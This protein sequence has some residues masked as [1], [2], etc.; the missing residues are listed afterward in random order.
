M[1]VCTCLDYW[2]ITTIVCL[3]VQRIVIKYWILIAIIKAMITKET[4]M[5]Y[6]NYKGGGEDHKN[7]T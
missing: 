6:V 4:F 7:L 5:Y 1:Y 2:V 3:H